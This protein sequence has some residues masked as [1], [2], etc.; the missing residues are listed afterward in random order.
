MHIWQIQKY[1][2]IKYID[3]QK[4]LFYFLKFMTN[5]RHFSNSRTFQDCTYSELKHMKVQVHSSP[6][7]TLKQNQGQ[8]TFEKSRSIMTFLTKSIVTGT[9]CSLI[10]I[11]KEKTGKYIPKSSKL[12]F[13][14]K[15]SANIL[16]FSNVEDNT[17]LHINRRSIA[18]FC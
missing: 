9:L 1:R 14:E 8:I 12:G 16:I 10:L 5:P 3:G 11:L 13:L 15:I 2:Q 4:Y 18:D 7:P 17:H 6:E